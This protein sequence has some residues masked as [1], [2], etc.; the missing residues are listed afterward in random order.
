MHIH[1][2][3]KDNY[4]LISLEGRIDSSVA[5][6][7]ESEMLECVQKECTNILIEGQNLDYISSAGLRVFLIVAKLLK[8]KQ[9]KLALF[10]LKSH[11]K[12]VFDVSGFST[13]L[14]IFNSYDEA[15]NF[16]N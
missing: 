2:Q 8:Q 7:F 16:L 11:I 4:M 5:K 3:E 15:K 12:E 6:E 9:G 14:P 1:V 13:L 10:S